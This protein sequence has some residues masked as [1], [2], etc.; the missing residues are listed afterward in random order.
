MGKI[1]FEETRAIFYLVL[2]LFLISLIFDFGVTFYVISQDK[3]TFIY[4]ESNMQFIEM[5]LYHKI[6]MEE[7]G[8]LIII[9]VPCF[10]FY[11]AYKHK[12]T[13]F[14][15]FLVYISLGLLVANIIAHLMG[16]LSWF[17]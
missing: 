2:I 13:E 8:K 3:T 15:K 14:N 9:L 1:T 4:N 10:V 7:I 12:R 6:P 16:G 17:W 5:V 11:F